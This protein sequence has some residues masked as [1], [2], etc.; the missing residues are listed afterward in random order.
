MDIYLTWQ[1]IFW[2]MKDVVEKYKKGEKLDFSEVNKVMEHLIHGAES[3]KEMIVN[4]RKIGDKAFYDMLKEFAYITWSLDDSRKALRT[5]P[6][7]EIKIDGF[8]P[9]Y[10][11]FQFVDERGGYYRYGLK[12]IKK[13]I[14]KEKLMELFDDNLE[15]INTQV[16]DVTDGSHFGSKAWISTAQEYAKEF[17]ER[18]FARRLK[19]LNDTKFTK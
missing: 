16:M 5:I 10:D 6:T 8:G 2:E 9:F 11:E 7:E 18:G 3:C 13:H 12:Y 19:Q 15:N 4:K 1:Q 17:E 14:T